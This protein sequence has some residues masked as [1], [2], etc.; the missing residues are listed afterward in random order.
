[1]SVS[2]LESRK[3]LCYFDLPKDKICN[4]DDTSEE[5]EGVL[6]LSVFCNIGGEQTSKGTLSLVDLRGFY[7]VTP[8][9]NYDVPVMNRAK[10]HNN[11]NDDDDNRAL[12]M[13]MRSASVKDSGQANDTDMVELPLHN[14]NTVNISHQS[15]NFFI[16]LQKNY[17]DGS[18]E[19]YG[20]LQWIGESK[21]VPQ[22]PFYFSV[23]L[24][25]YCHKHYAHVAF[26]TIA[27]VNTLASD[28]LR[29]LLLCVAPLLTDMMQIR[30]LGRTYCYSDVFWVLR[31]IFLYFRNSK[32][33]FPC[34]FQDDALVALINH[35]KCTLQHEPVYLASIGVISSMCPERGDIRFQGDVYQQ[36]L[37]S[38]SRCVFDARHQDLYMKICA[39][40][41]DDEKG[42]TILFDSNSFSEFFRC[43]RKS[44]LFL[45]EVDLNGTSIGS[46]FY[47]LYASL[48]CVVP[49]LK[50]AK[51]APIVLPNLYRNKSEV[52]VKV[53]IDRLENFF[54]EELW[55]KLE[56]SNFLNGTKSSRDVRNISSV[57]RA[58]E[59]VNLFLSVE[60]RNMNN[61][62]KNL[63]GALC[64]EIEKIHHALESD[65]SISNRDTTMTILDPSRFERQL[66][67]PLSSFDSLLRH[68]TELSTVLESLSNLCKEKS[69]FSSFWSLEEYN[70]GLHCLQ[71][72]DLSG[73]LLH[74]AGKCDDINSRGEKSS[75][76]LVS[77][78][79]ISLKQPWAIASGEFRPVAI[80][81]PAKPS[82]FVSGID[83]ALYL[84]NNHEARTVVGSGPGNKLGDFAVAQIRAAR[85]L[86]PFNLVINGSIVMLLVIADTGNNVLKGLVLSSSLGESSSF[87]AGKIFEL[88]KLNN[89]VSMCVFED[90]II[91]ASQANHVLYT[92]SYKKVHFYSQ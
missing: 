35:T 29:E 21:D 18:F 74:W 86:C 36:E 55:K 1:M 80:Q 82:V 60:F 84:I 30:P 19:I 43:L 28:I 57:R 14:V 46:K 67:V 24:P 70:A 39:V 2:S 69:S 71:R 23:Q 16:P 42:K 25:S 58:E 41:G 61:I 89:P 13:M 8:Q 11:D 20:T 10:S 81:K 15:Y 59:L 6:V 26:G 53:N 75:G 88:A 34:L 17:F 45:L 9:G 54:T 44:L 27:T 66:N 48:S 4:I 22:Q 37:Y 79:A 83:S 76:L 63:M 38:I 87:P 32:S 5:T 47:P 65:C 78:S 68:S 3:A 64:S 33:F 56:K 73:L 12:P 90:K 62:F 52:V 85:S 49:L 40:S 31:A 7:C 91:V 51:M 50:K 77:P 92:V 72:N